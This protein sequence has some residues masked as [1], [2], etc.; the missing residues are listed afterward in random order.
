LQRNLGK[1]KDGAVQKPKKGMK[2]GWGK[3]MVKGGN[4][5]RV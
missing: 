2:E 4:L 1:K 3:E 5:T